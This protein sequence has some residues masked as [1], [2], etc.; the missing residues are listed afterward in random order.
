MKE[1]KYGFTYWNM[2]QE[3]GRKI[4]TDQCNGVKELG[5]CGLHWKL[6]N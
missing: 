1:K 2:K 3:L 5:L 4:H 6:G